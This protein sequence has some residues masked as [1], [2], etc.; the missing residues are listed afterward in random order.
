MSDPKN[1]PDVVANAVEQ[2]V[3]AAEE[4]HRSIAN[5]PLDMIE[6]ADVIGDVVCEVRRIQNKG[7]GA[8]YD[9][10]RGINKEVNKLTHELTDDP[11]P[12]KTA[13]PRA[14]A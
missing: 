14:A 10:V 2:G 6:R 12:K 5:F 11:S 4:I 3:N 7:I 13:R 9:L 8:V 1:L